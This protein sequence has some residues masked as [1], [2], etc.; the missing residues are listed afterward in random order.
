MGTPSA[1]VAFSTMNAAARDATAMN[2]VASATC[3][4]GHI[5]CASQPRMR[6]RRSSCCVPPTE[7]ECSVHGR[8]RGGSVQLA[9]CS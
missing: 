9:V 6:V 4:P 3:I 5:L 7:T 8:I 1:S 2:M